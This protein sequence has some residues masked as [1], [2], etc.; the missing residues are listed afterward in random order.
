[1]ATRGGDVGESDLACAVGEEVVERVVDEVVGAAFVLRRYP[2]TGQKSGFPG[3]GGTEDV[4]QRQNVV[5]A[6]D[7]GAVADGE[8]LRGGS[9][10]C[11]SVN[12][13]S[14]AARARRGSMARSS[15]NSCWQSPIHCGWNW[16]TTSRL[17][18]CS[19]SPISLI[20]SCGRFEPTRTR[21]PA[22]KRP[23]WS[24]TMERPVPCWIRWISNSGW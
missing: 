8:Q 20:Q 3:W 24:P 18:M 23:M 9:R 6:V 13:M 7:A 16:K 22:V 14:R 2:G 15:G 19:P 17:V 10:G 12:S 5:E 21:C 1:M 4:E 11:W